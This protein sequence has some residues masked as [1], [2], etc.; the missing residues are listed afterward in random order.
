[1]CGVC[2]RELAQSNELMNDC[3]DPSSFYRA[4]RD[5]LRAYRSSHPPPLRIDD[6]AALT[7]WPRWA[8]KK[9]RCAPPR[10]PTC[11]KQELKFIFIFSPD[12]FFSCMSSLYDDE[13]DEE[14]RNTPIIDTFLPP[15][16]TLSFAE[17]P[18]LSAS[19]FGVEPPSMISVQF[20]NC[21]RVRADQTSLQNLFS[22]VTLVDGSR[23]TTTTTFD[24]IEFENVN[25]LKE[26]RQQLSH[27]DEKVA[28]SAWY[29][30]DVFDGLGKFSFN[31][32]GAVTLASLDSLLR[33]SKPLAEF[34][35]DVRT[36]SEPSTR[37]FMQHRFCF[38]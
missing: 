23:A 38:C 9:K 11:V 10:A 16:D 36:P 5:A 25:E 19:E 37:L 13:L 26:L 27:V 6:I 2:I 30:S 4:Q 12:F 21:A 34:S 1:M 24:E 28:R 8:K 3:C 22:K 18:F 20:L 7:S 29:G 17:G 15:A 14:Y 33:F 31:N 35:N 32:P